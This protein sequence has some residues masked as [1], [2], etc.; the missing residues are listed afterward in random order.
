MIS[1]SGNIFSQITG[2]SGISFVP[3][4]QGLHTPPQSTSNSPSSNTLF[5]QDSGSVDDKVTVDVEVVEKVTVDVEE[6]EEVTVDVEVVEKVT[7]D[8]EEGEEVTVDVDVVEEVTFEARDVSTVRED[9]SVDVAV[10]EEVTSEVV[11]VEVAAV[12]GSECG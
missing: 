3:S 6:G 12:D 8:V 10:V 11:T 1:S 5:A 7:V 2:F 4:K 9:I